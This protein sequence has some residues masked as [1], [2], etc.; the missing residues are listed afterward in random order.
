MTI[1]GLTYLIF[2]L[3]VWLAAQ[4]T[5]GARP[6]QAL[7]L[8]ASAVFYA[9]WGWHAFA[10]LGFSAVM[11]FLLLQHL[12]RNPTAGRLWLG[13]ACNLALLATFKY[14]APHGGGGGINLIPAA[15]LRWGVPVGV[16]FWTFQ[17]LSALLD[18]Y[19]GED[20][21]PSFAEYAL[22]LS[23]WPVVLSGPVCR[24]PNM[25]PQFRNPARVGSDDV[26]EGVRR[27][28]IGLFMKLFLA[29]VLASGILPEQG[30]NVGFDQL[31]RGWSG[32]D[33]WVLAVGYG[34][35]IFFD[36]AGYSHIAIGTARLFGL[37]I[38]EN[39]N[40]PYLSTTPSVFWTRW[41]MSLSFWIRDYLF[42]PLA[43]LRREIW[44]RNLALAAS[45]LIFGLWHGATWGYVVWGAYQGLLLVLHRQWQAIWKRLS[46]GGGGPAAD[47]AG[48]AVTMGAICLGWLPFR[49]HTLSEAW[50]MC[51][52]LVT[53]AH[54]FRFGLDPGLYINT[55]FLV[56]GYFA[57]IG[58]R[59]I[60][61]R[62]VNRTALGD[63]VWLVSPAYYSLLLT[64][65]ILW[66]SQKTVFV[67]LK[68]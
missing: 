5:R 61:R 20:L 37:R 12:R 8:G 30:L 42:F 52:A 48:W 59:A 45:M 62:L 27:I 56:S 55:F 1:L 65:I 46:P 21:D 14:W 33:V 34:F 16:S 29:R 64:I 39:F 32:L 3:L 17:A 67:Y 15:L 31:S 26:A 66:S 36:F 40:D 38:P 47:F 7:L 60:Y 51:R 25:L 57:F 41:H 43:T 13:L 11:N 44:W 23:F 50:L 10:V 6:R 22:Y 68:F 19:K 53:P 63:W 18:C 58:L 35:Q 24:L 4:L 54:Y 9:T 2:L 49:C 28:V